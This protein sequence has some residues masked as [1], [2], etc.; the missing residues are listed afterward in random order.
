MLTMKAPE[1]RQ[2][3]YSGVFIV[4]FEYI[5]HLF[6]VFLLL[7]LNKVN[8]SREWIFGGDLFGKIS[9]N[10]NLFNALYLCPSCRNKAI[11]IHC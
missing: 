11:D 7:T 8:V 2:R 4:N 10:I 9:V 5:S 1:W 3:H 6:L